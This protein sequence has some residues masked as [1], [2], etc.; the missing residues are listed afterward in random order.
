[1]NNAPHLGQLI[2]KYRETI[3]MSKAELAR[4]INTSRQNIHLI[5]AKKSLD[6]DQLRE[7]S[8]ALNH[9][10]FQYLAPAVRMQ[11]QRVTLRF[12]E[13]ELVGT[14]EIEQLPPDD[15]PLPQEHMDKDTD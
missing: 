10:F 1:M 11:P 7:I 13:V 14:L 4:R 2:D 12:S 9:D 3:G 6:T 5:L 15:F 8:N